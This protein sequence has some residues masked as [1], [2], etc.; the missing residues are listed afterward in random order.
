MPRDTACCALA[1][2]FLSPMALLAQT[3]TKP[4]SCQETAKRVLAP[5]EQSL[6]R[7]EAAAKEYAQKNNARIKSIEEAI[8]FRR[9]LR[10][11]FDAFREKDRA[12]YRGRIAAAAEA[13]VL[14]RQRAAEKL[15]GL[16]ARLQQARSEKRE[17][18]AKALQERIAR[19]QKL[20]AAG[21]V[22]AHS[23]KLGWGHSM[24]GWQKFLDE[25]TKRKE[26]R[27]AKHAAGKMRMHIREFGYGL[28]WQGVLDQIKR[29]QKELS[30]ARAR[31]PRYHLSP[32]GFGLNGQGID[33]YLSKKRSELADAHARIAAGSFRLHVRTLGYQTD[34]NAVQKLIHEAKEDYRKTYLAWAAKSYRTHNP[35]LGYSQSNG[36][37][38]ARLAKEREEL[39]TYQAAGMDAPARSSGR[40]QKGSD[41]Q[42]QLAHASRERNQ[43]LIAFYQKALAEWRKN[44]S[45]HILKSKERIARTEKTLKKHQELWREDL[46]RQKEQIDGRLAHALAETPCAGG[47]TGVRDP[48]AGIVERQV[49]KITRM[50][51][52]DKER[53]R[54]LNDYWDRIYREPDGTVHGD[55]K[56]AWRKALRDLPV[57]DGQMSLPEYVLWL[58]NH[59]DWLIGYVDAAKLTAFTLKLESIIRDIEALDPRGL[60][61]EEFFKQRKALRGR[62]KGIEEALE[63]GFLSPSRI[64]RYINSLVKSGSGSKK[65][66]E[67]LKQ[68]QLLLRNSQDAKRML[69]GWTAIKSVAAQFK[70]KALS[71]YRNFVK[72]SADDV[73]RRL[74]GA[75][76]SM[77]KFEKGLLVMS[78][79]NAAADAY[80]QIQKGVAASEAIAR[81]ST[82]FVI[83]MVI[84]AVP[85]LAAAE[86]GTQILFTSYATAT[87]D[88]GVSDATL[89]N[90]VKWATR[91]A[92]DKVAAGAVHLGRLSIAL[93]RFASGKPGIAEVLANVDRSQLRMALSR[94]EER[95]GCLV[96]GHPDEARL[97]RA[98]QAFRRLLRAK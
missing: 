97:M 9:S 91:K 49:D 14:A 93:E 74:D 2:L 31:K 15:R 16:Q 11:R 39:A 86:M 10:T 18:E 80:S 70:G 37:L 73:A 12:Y 78:I 46:K 76:G 23:Q 40:K 42:K 64:Q 88:Q 55:P 7:A 85:I 34:R 61:P 44:R 65:T 92:L 84:G 69:K 3:R 33:A 17:S 47:S 82:D 81:A 66:R 13:Q 75:F 32:L 19:L 50:S 72:G 83:D 20:I 57:G 71:A 8:H 38:E 21:A 6:A 77:S 79:A 54:R 27:L 53:E 45:I 35:L 28:D 59:L 25:E 96:P 36:D 87:G 98:R 52:S 58:K 56:D 1:L 68:M 95:I 89:S 51:E 24:K 26:Q 41:I 60:S 43:R 22:R 67:Q 29:K 30:E 62:L 4:A 63:G 94:V 48:R 90:T 5:F